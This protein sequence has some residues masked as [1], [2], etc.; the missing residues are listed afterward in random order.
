MPSAGTCLG[1]GAVK[2]SA[3]IIDGSSPIRQV[4][5][6]SIQ[7]SRFQCHIPGA[8]AHE[9]ARISIQHTAAAR[10][11]SLAGHCFRGSAKHSASAVELCI[12][13]RLSIDGVSAAYES[14]SDDLLGF[15]GFEQRYSSVV[16]TGPSLD[17]RV[18]C[19]C[20]TLDAVPLEPPCR[21]GDAVNV[22]HGAEGRLAAAVVA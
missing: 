9:R 4:V 8:N 6:M 18:Q 12:G 19:E 15:G 14:N 1:C 17:A 21:P 22:R 5:N 20:L 16:A 13:D 10:A 2:S 11:A 7:G 3:E